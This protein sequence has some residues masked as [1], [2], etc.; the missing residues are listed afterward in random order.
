MNLSKDD[1]R[2]TD[3]PL[4]LDCKPHSNMKYAVT[5]KQFT[6]PAQTASLC[7]IMPIPMWLTVQDQLNA[8]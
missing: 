2:D 5:I 1:L 3:G 8:P 4:L 6:A 7:C